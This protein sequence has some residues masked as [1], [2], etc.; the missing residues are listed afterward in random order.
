MRELGWY[1][2]QVYVAR[3]LVRFMNKLW[4]MPASTMARRAMLESWHDYLDGHCE[5]GW[6]A[7]VQT[8][9]VAAG[10]P[11]KEYLPDDARIPVYDDDIVVQT[12]RHAC[13]QVF[14]LPG[15]PS[16]L[17]AYHTDFA[18][19]LDSDMRARRN[20]WRRALHFDLP[21]SLNKLKLLTRFR[22]SC[23][24]LAIE[25]GRWYNID[26]D[27]RKCQLCAMGSVQDE[28]HVMFI[29]PALQQIR[30]KYPLLFG[31]NRFTHIRQMMDFSDMHNWGAV[32]RDICRFLHEIGGIYSPLLAPDT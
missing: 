5:D 31:N 3:Q 14:L 20:G 21:I 2:L 26:I 29:C 32:A 7:R 15:L 12:L 22:L 10:V 27:Q 17:A 28:H 25:T 13:H 30:N 6:C 18:M 1:P 9:L 23:H 16:K 4:G 19:P 8:F 11:I 24:H